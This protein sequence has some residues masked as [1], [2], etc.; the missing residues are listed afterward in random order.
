MKNRVVITSQG[1]VCPLGINVEEFEERMFRGDSAVVGI[2][3]S[4]VD[5]TFPVPHAALVDRSR[6]PRTPRIQHLPESPA[7]RF[8]Q[9]SAE[10]TAQALR[11]L[12][13]KHRIDAILYGTAEGISYELGMESLAPGFDFERFDW[14]TTRPETSLEI[15]N[16]VLVDHGFAPVD[17]HNRIS[18]NSACATG[19]QAIGIAYQNIQRGQWTRALVGGVDA[20]C[21]PSNLMNFHLL[22]ALTAANVPSATA[23]RPF[24]RTRSGFV[25]GEG[26]A[27]LILESMDSARERGATIL[28]EVVG[29]GNT[30][31]AYRMTDGREDCASVVRAMERAIET[32][33]IG[34]EAIDY[35]NA[36]GTST[37]LN[38][39]LETKAIKLVFGDRAPRIPVSSLKSQLG[40]STVAAGAVEAVA[41]VLM[42]QRQ[43]IA[44]T[45]NYH[46]P[47]PD[48]D[49]DYVPNQSRNA[50]V[51]F[52]LSNNFGFGGQNACLV[53][54][55]W[56]GA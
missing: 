20:R 35:I 37:A 22:G 14:N 26:A 17:P 40:H 33:G 29:Y 45:I 13:A 41:C 44:P 55:R 48:C 19:N 21:G 11:G 8:W 31:D 6:V 28:A 30:S 18:I 56:E 7:A 12:D 27:T 32:A 1:V 15:I 43:R 49:L 3:G 39:R 51:H 36:H 38:D 10:A 9:F 24:D 50:R 2:R 47:D 52:V 4:I 25:R 34:K 42:L 54:R 16:D 53:F 46:E 5:E 23:S